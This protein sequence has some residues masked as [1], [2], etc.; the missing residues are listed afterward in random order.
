[1]LG[2]VLLFTAGPVT[3]QTEQP[4]TVKQEQVVQTQAPAAA[5]NTAAE[6]SAVNAGL[7]EY[8]PEK[9]MTPQEKFADA[10]KT[11][12]IVDD[13]WEYLASGVIV[14]LKIS[15]FAV[16]L[17]I[18]TGFT[19][20]VIRSTWDRRPVNFKVLAHYTGV[21]FRSTW[22]RQP[23]ASNGNNA[24][25]KLRI[26]FRLNLLRIYRTFAIVIPFVRASLLA[27]LN[28]FCKIYLTVIRGTPTVV[29]L[30]IIYFV[31]LP[32][33]TNKLLV[34]VIAFG[35]NSSAYVAEIIRSG[36]MSTDK[37]QFEAGHSLGLTYIQTML[38]IILPQAFKNVLPALGNEFIV[39]V[40]ETS[41]C[42]FIAMQDLTKGGNIIRSQTY[43]AFMPL[44][45]VALIYL[46]IVMLLTWLLGMLE[47][48][49]K[50]NE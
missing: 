46:M 4:Q 22:R 38:F 43:D 48:R 7:P 19:I 47:R 17:G 37:G 45:A 2:A 28:V 16:L 12:F 14:T 40:K 44:I 21:A 18:L 11:N 39:L 8:E 49:L 10:F 6:P 50:K 26:R 25:R 41:I 3:A 36:I 34:A 35:I 30:L 27:F 5:Q 32:T 15:F 33:C 29:Q 1:M 23:K 31:V 24:F 42:E 9:E 20:A 13:R